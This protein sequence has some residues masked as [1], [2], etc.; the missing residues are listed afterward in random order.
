MIS[1]L[2]SILFG[3][4]DADRDSAS[5]ADE[6]Q[7]AA[8]ALLV[9]SATM[10]GAFG[11]REREA[12]ERVL[13]ARFK[14]TAEET[15]ALIDKAERRVADSIELY[16][17]TRVVKDNLAPDERGQVIEMLW[18]VAYAD[19]KLHDYEAGLVRRVAGLLFVPDRESG[20]ARQ[21]VLS[22]LDIEDTSLK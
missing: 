5:S 10:D 20:E 2:K 8:A 9:E 13:S 16:S 15:Q 11:A 19:G 7:L 14:L 21:R 17:F 22:R 18:E 6:L 4:E 1:G 3:T 12:M